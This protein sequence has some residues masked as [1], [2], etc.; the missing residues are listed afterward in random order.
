MTTTCSVL[1]VF[2]GMLA[3]GDYDMGPARMITANLRDLI[4]QAE[5]SYLMT[6]LKCAPPE[7]PIVFEHHASKTRFIF[8]R[9]TAG[10]LD[11]PPGIGEAY[12]VAQQY[13]TE[14]L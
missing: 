4:I 3:C 9:W 6:N 12:I 13:T 5:S 14:T 7:S 2:Q 10:R 11:S 8:S 1:S